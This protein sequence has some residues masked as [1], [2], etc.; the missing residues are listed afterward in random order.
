MNEQRWPWL[1][2]L[3]ADVGLF[4][5]Y[6]ALS[7][8]ALA[9]L[10]TA[11]SALRPTESIAAAGDFPFGTLLAGAACYAASFGLWLLVLA[12]HPIGIAYP[13]AIGLSVLTVLLADFF[14]FQRLISARE[15]FGV[16]LIL[17]GVVFVFSAGAGGDGA[18]R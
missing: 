17:A 1:G 10:K 6:A 9:L 5:A 8:V 14:W 4:V 16:A 11:M 12:R 3:A 7:A 13:I 2:G 15:L 18:L